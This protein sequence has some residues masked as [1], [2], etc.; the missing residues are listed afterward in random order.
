MSIIRGF[1][2]KL[3]PDAEQAK[4]MDQWRRAALSLWN[5]LLGMEQAAYDGSKFR[6]ELHWRQIWAEIVRE[7][8]LAAVHTWR[9]G[10]YTKAGVLKK[11]PG[12]GKEPVEPTSEYYDKISGCSVNGEPPK[13]FIWQ[14]DLKKI[15]ARLKSEALSQW[16]AVLPSHAAQQVCD[17]INDAIR[18]M[19]SERSKRLRGAGGRNTGFP[20]FKKHRY[21]AGSVYMV[22]VQTAFDHETR[23]VSLPKLKLPMPFRQ[24]DLPTEGLMGGRLW[25]QGEQWWLSCQFKVPDLPPLPIRGREC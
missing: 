10:K 14:S 8:Y 19:L 2:I 16:V 7:D 24:E 22:N 17:D 15:M 25:R 6:P 23:M 18:T 5:L 12:S 9:H 21:A 13:L 20:R 4:V 1:K 11:A 3:T